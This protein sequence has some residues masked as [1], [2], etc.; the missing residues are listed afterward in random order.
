MQPVLAILFHVI[1]HFWLMVVIVV[2]RLSRAFISD[3][4]N[5]VTN[6]LDFVKGWLSTPAPLPTLAS[7]FGGEEITKESL[8]S[9]IIP[10]YNEV[11][12]LRNTLDA[13]MKA[14]DSN[15]EIILVDGGSVDESKEIAEEYGLKIFHA[16]TGR[17]VCQNF[18]AS[19]ANG[20]ILLFLHADT[21]V[22]L[23]FGTSIRKAL[24]DDRNL[25]GAFRFRIDDRTWFASILELGTN[26][27]ASRF[28]L[29][30]GD[31]ALFVRK[32]IFEKM[33]KFPNQRLMEDYEF[34]R[35]VRAKGRIHIVDDSIAISSR[36]WKR[37]GYL[38][39]LVTNQLIIIAYELGIT[40]DR[41]ASW[42]YPPAVHTK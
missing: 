28:Q 42:Y 10:I 34:V 24:A 8:I 26:I 41:L 9:V 39:C 20:T 12:Q 17:S 27:R 38:N 30:Y 3:P 35:Q 4:R 6:F 13:L 16:S 36:R 21:C 31:Q 37:L 23:N 5:T 7:S 32:S 40:P 22:P 2:F 29:P 19:K 18:G 11:N 1:L 33:G 25:L 14:R 15:T